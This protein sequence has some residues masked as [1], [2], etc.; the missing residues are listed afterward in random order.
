MNETNY[1]VRHNSLRNINETEWRGWYETLLTWYE[2]HTDQ[3]QQ[4]QFQFEKDKL[5]LLEAQ[6]SQCYHWALFEVVKRQIKLED[7]LGQDMPILK[8]GL[9]E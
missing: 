6:T 7:R 5:I 1:K 2:P 8:K 4:V 3:Y 9:K